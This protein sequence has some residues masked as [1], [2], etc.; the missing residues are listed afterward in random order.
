LN[1]YADSQIEL[2]Q[3]A[4]DKNF[5]SKTLAFLGKI[6][7]ITKENHKSTITKCF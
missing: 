1:Y 5:S 3:N 4:D 6:G 7:Y 2:S